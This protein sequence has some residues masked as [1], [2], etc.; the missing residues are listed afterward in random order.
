MK[1]EFIHNANSV[2]SRIALG[3][4]DPFGGGGGGGRI[5]SED[6]LAGTEF[7]GSGAKGKYV[8]PHYSCTVILITV[9]HLDGQRR[10]PL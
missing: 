5:V 4:V 2:I 3:H 8:L 1:W 9:V 6:V 7:S 10:E